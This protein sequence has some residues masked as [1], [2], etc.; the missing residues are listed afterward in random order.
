M[1]TSVELMDQN[2]W[3]RKPK[4]ILKD[5]YIVAAAA[6]ETTETKIVVNKEEILKML[7]QTK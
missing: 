7:R 5:K 6:T 2:P 1:S 4:A 3:W